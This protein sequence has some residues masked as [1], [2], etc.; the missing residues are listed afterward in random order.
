MA[1]YIITPNMQLLA[2]ITGTSPGPDYANQQNTSFTLIDGHDHSA[3]KGVQ[4]TPAGLNINSA[5]AINNQL[6][7]AVGLINFT[8]Q[9]ST[10]ATPQGLYVTVGSG[11][12]VEDLFFTDGAG[13]IIQ[14]T[15]SGIVNTIAS[16]IPGE[17][18]SGGTFIW[19]QTQSALPTTP[20]NF[21]IGSI[22]IRPS[23]AAT[24]NGA[25][26]VGPTGTAYTLTLPASLPA[27]NSFMLLDSSGNITASISATA[28]ITGSNIA[29]ATITGSNIA[30]GTVTLSNLASS[31]LQWNTST[32]T[33]TGTFTV[34]TGVNFLVVKACGGGGSGGAGTGTNNSIAT[35]AGASGG[36][37]SL[38]QNTS[39]SV[40]AGQVYTVTIGAGGTGPAGVFGGGVAGGNGGDTIVSITGPSFTGNRTSGSRI[41][42]GVS[43]IAGLSAGMAVTG[44]G[45]ASGTYIVSVDTGT[46]ITLS[47]AASSGAAT[48]T[49]F[50]SQTNY[51]Y[52]TGGVGGTADTTDAGTTAPTTP[53][54]S[55]A[56]KALTAAG[57]VGG[58]NQLAGSS[59]ADSLYA[60]GGTFGTSGA[61]IG[62]GGGGGAAG[63]GPGGVGG[64]GSSG[65]GQGG[66]GTAPAATSYGA[67]GGGGGGSQRSITGGFKG[68]NG[69]NGAPGVV[70]FNWLGNP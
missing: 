44:T 5:L 57:G 2:P 6:L 24:T 11:T 14:I 63:M 7:N 56:P 32:I 28:G 43:S 51:L 48:V 19:T 49:S 35:T 34:P 8:A 37:S 69:G 47:N 18:Y 42:T 54:S 17:S 31:V 3:G 4:I 27:S 12:G 52:I 39:L 26:L 70:I 62:G 55:W 65:G 66:A 61:S 21:D 38:F 40:T 64:N 25:T 68:G 46:Q 10:S 53:T 50:T 22:T 9:S 45:F 13:N 23:I 29:S 36:S 60:Q 58:A 20:A 1:T 15:K 33:T 41:V 16:T 30:A 67:G 59:G